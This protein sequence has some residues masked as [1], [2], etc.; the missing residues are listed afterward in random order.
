MDIMLGDYG[1][2]MTQEK[3]FLMKWIKKLR[4]ISNLPN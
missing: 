3:N 4:P 2:D 1:M